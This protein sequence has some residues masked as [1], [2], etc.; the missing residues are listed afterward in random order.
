MITENRCKKTLA[1]G[2]SCLVKLRYT[3]P[4]ADGTDSGNLIFSDNAPISPQTVSLQG[5]SALPYL[6]LYGNAFNF[7]D[8]IVGITSA[9]IFVQALNQGYLPIHISSVTATT[10]FAAIN[11]C[12]PVLVPGSYCEIGATFTP[13]VGGVTY[14]T[15]YINDDAYGSPQTI[16]LQGNGLTTYP[17]PTISLLEPSSAKSGSKPVQVWIYGSEFFPT[18]TVTV[19]G[20]AVPAK[21]LY[22]DFFQITVP[23]SLLK[24]VGNLSIQVVNPSPGGA[25]APAGFAVYNQATVGAADMIYEPFTQKIYA[26]IPASS[27][28]NPNSLVTVDPVTGTVGVP[29][30]IGNDPGVMGLSSDGT[31]LY[32]GL[33]GD[34][35][36]VP[37]NLQTQTAGTEIPLGSDPQKGSFTAANLQVQPG[38]PTT[39]VA[40]V[41]AGY[42][43]ADG[44]ELIE[45]GKVVSDF[46]DEPPNNIA[47]GGTRF[48]GAGDFYGWSNIW[49]DWGLNQFVIRGSSL[50][51]TTGIAGEYGI[52]P[53]D[54]DGTYLFD[55]D[56]QVFKAADGT[57]VGTISGINNYSPEAGVLA[58]VSSGRT[59]FLDQYGTILS[60]DSKTLQIVGST[61]IAANSP[62]SRLLHWGPDG[63]DFPTLNYTNTYDLI[64]S[65]SSLFFPSTTQNPLPVAVSTS[66]S[67][68]ASGGSN[69][70][71]TVKGS[72]FVRGAVV[73]WN[74]AS[75]TTT[76]VSSTKLVADI[77]WSDISKPGTAQ[78]TV[79]NPSPGGGQS[80]A[81]KLLI[82]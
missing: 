13:S 77:P 64:I 56:G 54:T 5:Y 58:D 70:V 32:V 47:V 66:P 73:N 17:T 11:K 62:P 25:S 68:V 74:G 41:N 22:Q 14:G 2:Q 28:T 76:W 34:N 26:S 61:S 38:H 39:V 40:T 50:Y 8:Q 49:N 63:V 20:K 29:I 9:P 15:L 35:S 3:P 81:V 33:N 42:N 65:R 67:A 71:L 12:P 72:E 48:V 16:S 44:I 55:V 53:F 24:K 69:F 52:G 51:E 59:F 10:S 60:V 43:G 82:Q 36:V 7:G 31:T 57:L 23:G 19:N 46:L 27:A 18:S 37:F 21:A 75:R 1:A 45:N 80:G 30:P 6:T 79:V 4:V 78:I